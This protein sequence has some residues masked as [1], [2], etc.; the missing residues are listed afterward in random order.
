MV[1]YY[2]QFCA[3]GVNKGK[4]TAIFDALPSQ[5]SKKEKKYKISTVVKNARMRD[6]ENA[7]MWL[8]DGMIANPCFNATDPNVG[9]SLSFDHT[10]HKLYMADTGLLVQ[11]STN[12]RPQNLQLSTNIRPQNL[13]FSANIRP[14][15]LHHSAN[16]R[17]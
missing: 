11:L 15:N 8:A 10:T 6:Y 17:P 9:L 1:I 5:L 7:F 13:H 4:V 14:H 3:I 2:L 16:I 12:I